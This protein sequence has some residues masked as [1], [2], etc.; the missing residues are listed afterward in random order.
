M[1][2]C[3]DGITNRHLDIVWH[4]LHISLTYV[5]TEQHTNNNE[6]FISDDDLKKMSD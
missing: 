1:S 5:T 2:T 4:L 6:G 3:L